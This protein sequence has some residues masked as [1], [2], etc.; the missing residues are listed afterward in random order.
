MDAHHMFTKTS[1]FQAQ[2]NR[3]GLNI[4]N[5]K[6]MSQW[7]SSAHRS[8]AHG[9]NKAWDGF[10][11]QFPNATRHQIEGSGSSLMKGY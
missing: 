4:H 2:W 5:P 11:K 3:V 10:F 9:Y 6:N 8:A 1:R 7:S